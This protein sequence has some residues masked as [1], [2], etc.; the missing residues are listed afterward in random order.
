MQNRCVSLDEVSLAPLVHAQDDDAPSPPS[1]ANKP[2][3]SKFIAY[4]QPIVAFTHAEIVD[5]TGGSA[6]YNQSLVIRDGRIAAIGPAHSN[7]IFGAMRGQVG[8]Y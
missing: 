8:L 1:V 3:D 2:H 6:N 4:N 7:A 5:G